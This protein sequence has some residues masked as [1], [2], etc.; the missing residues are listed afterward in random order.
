[1]VE[2]KRAEGYGCAEIQCGIEKERR[3]EERKVE[4]MSM[5][6]QSR[7]GSNQSWVFGKPNVRARGS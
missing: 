4:D 5:G 1:M 6:A 2:S 7:W 3:G